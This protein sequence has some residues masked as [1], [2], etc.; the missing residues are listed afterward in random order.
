MTQTTRTVLGII[1]FAIIVLISSVYQ[2]QPLLAFVGICMTLF[3]FG[4]Y[5]YTKIFTDKDKSRYGKYAKWGLIGLFI[6]ALVGGLYDLFFVQS[7]CC[8]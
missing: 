7:F 2:L 1:S 4:S 6:I 5:L 8:S 3:G